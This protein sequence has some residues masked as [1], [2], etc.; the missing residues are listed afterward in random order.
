MHRS[1]SMLNKFLNGPLKRIH[2][3]IFPILAVDIMFGRF[4]IFSVF[5]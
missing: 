2:Y 1:I 5:S 4:S 3:T